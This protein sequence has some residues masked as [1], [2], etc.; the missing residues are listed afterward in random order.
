MGLIITGR[1]LD[2]SAIREADDASEDLPMRPCAGI[3]LLNGKG[4]VWVGRRRPKWADNHIWQPPQGGIGRNER[5]LHAAFRELREET[6]ITSARLVAE[7]PQWLDYRLPRE[8]V[9]VALKGRFAGQ[10]LRWYALRFE[11]NES[12][13]DIDAKERVKPEFEAWRWVSLDDLP[14]LCLPHKRKVY[15]VVADAF[16]PVARQIADGKSL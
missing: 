8:L 13:I 14:R 15:E 10:R 4:R 7:L 11:G 6:G 16:A 3:V 12:E 2:R 1:T 9:G 5:P